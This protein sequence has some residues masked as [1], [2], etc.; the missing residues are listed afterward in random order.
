MTRASRTTASP[1]ELSVTVV[2]SV[3]HGGM[4]SKFRAVE[5]EQG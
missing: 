4:T 1:E 3:F 5:C 2:W